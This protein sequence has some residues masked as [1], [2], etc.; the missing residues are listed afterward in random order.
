MLPKLPRRINIL[1]VP[2]GTTQGSQGGFYA[3]TDAVVTAHLQGDN[4]H[5][6]SIR[7]IQTK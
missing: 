2:L 5:L 3:Q 1:N 4:V 6:F 7:D